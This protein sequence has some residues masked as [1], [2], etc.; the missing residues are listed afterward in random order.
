MKI[1]AVRSLLWVMNVF[2]L[3]GLVAL[4]YFAIQS[5][6]NATP[7][8]SAA[9][10]QKAKIVPLYDELRKNERKSESDTVTE[11]THA[12]LYQTV[13]DGTVAAPVKPVEETEQPI[14]PVKPKVKP[15]GEYIK[16]I[17]VYVDEGR[18]ELSSASVQHTPSNEW[19]LLSVGDEL[20]N[21]SP[22]AVLKEVQEYAIVFEYDVEN[23][24]NNVVAMTRRSPFD[25]SQLGGT[26]TTPILGGR[27]PAQE[28]AAR[29]RQ[30]GKGRGPNNPAT[31]EAP[32]ETYQDEN[33]MWHI[34]SDEAGQIAQNYE[35]MLGDLQ[36]QE[37]RDP[38]TNK[39]AGLQV[40]AV[41]EGSLAGQRGVRSSDILQRIDNR[42]ITNQASVINY[43]RS[44]QGR[45]VFQLTVLR[46]GRPVTMRFRSYPQR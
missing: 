1:K 10:I 5:R 22:K 42:P 36:L 8:R 43:I 35:Q 41:P 38:K 32:E 40:N 16:L 39:V 21:V 45:S 34:A 27:N 14:E 44:Q 24:D 3:L 28:A 37:Y 4:S 17:A 20:D 25:V 26:P 31:E 33:G 6:N 23:E 2:F 46:N 7:A 29:L 30:A 9:E 11:K 18:P 15:L 12:S 13:L 19:K